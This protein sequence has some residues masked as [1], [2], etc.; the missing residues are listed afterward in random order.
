[1]PFN[2]SQIK[3]TAQAGDEGIKTLVYGRSGVGKT[4]LL[5]TAPYPFIISGEKGLLSL[6]RCNPPLPYGEF[7]NQAQLIDIFKWCASSHEA[8]QFYTLGLDSVSEAAEVLLADLQKKY[9][10]DGRKVYP[11]LEAETMALLRAFRDLAW[12]SVVV[13]GKEE[14]DKDESGLMVYRP[15]LPGKKLPQAI[16]Y[17]FDETFRMLVGKDQ[18]GQD[19]R[20]LRTRLSGTE[21]ARDRS[22]MLNEF[23]PANLTYVFSKILGISQG[24]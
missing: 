4:P 19:M 10:N 20:Y 11:A 1:M 24:R 21:I 6:K 22:G 15:L 5:A 17:L 8:R 7:T 13:I 2:A 3:S 9:N 12:K 23:E 18:N 16:P 14:Y